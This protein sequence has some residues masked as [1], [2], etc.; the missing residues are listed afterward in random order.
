[1]RFLIFF[2]TCLF[3][4]S[5]NQP[6]NQCFANKQEVKGETTGSTKFFTDKL[7]SLKA[8][9][10]DR[11]N[12]KKK[13]ENSSG[14][15]DAVGNLEASGKKFSSN[16]SLV[17]QANGVKSAGGSKQNVKGK[18]IN[19]DEFVINS[20]STQCPPRRFKAHRFKSSNSE[21]SKELPSPKSTY[22]VAPQQTSKNRF[23][24]LYG[25]QKRKYLAHHHY[26]Q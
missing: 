13:D 7:K 17:S 6:T 19:K 15:A 24:R 12:K 5:M 26:R 14:A 9:V 25:T 3:I 16:G 1:M 18:K 10:R 22:S 2:F 11:K 20:N 21:N 8:K 4:F 23:S